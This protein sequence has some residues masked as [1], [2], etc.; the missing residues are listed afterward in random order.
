[1]SK[2]EF[3][4]NNT[5]RPVIRQPLQAVEM[6]TAEAINY[7][8]ETQMITQEELQELFNY[9]P[10]TGILTRAKDL[11]KGRWKAGDTIGFDNGNGYKRTIIKGKK[12]YIH[13]IIWMYVYGEMP[14]VIDHINGNKSDNRISN[15]RNTNYQGNGYNGNIRG[16]SSKYKGVTFHKSTQKWRAQIHINGTGRSLG[17][18][19]TEEEAYSARLKAEEKYGVGEYFDYATNI[20]KK[21]IDKKESE[22]NMSGYKNIYKRKNGYEISIKGKY[23][24]VYKTI[25]EARKALERIHNGT[26]T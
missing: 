12:Y 18:Y 13:R 22:R 26:T 10:E 7:D 21:F 24:S 17:L 9:N 23:Y 8:G 2:V 3:R 19:N 1:M 6:H 4:Y 15:L 16:G 11:H 20:P 25:D 14:K 5:I